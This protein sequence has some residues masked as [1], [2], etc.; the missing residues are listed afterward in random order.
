MTPVTGGTAGM[1]AGGKPWPRMMV[2]AMALDGLGVLAL[3]IPAIWLITSDITANNQGGLAT[4]VGYILLVPAAVFVIAGLLVLT[5]YKWARLVHSALTIIWIA[6]W[7][8]LLSMLR[9]PFLPALSIC[10]AA[11]TVLMWLP[12]SKQF[13]RQS[14]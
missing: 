14:D 10:F 7:I 13:F 9:T 6:V 3:V 4:I 8:D 5:R 1:T 2:I 12:P 11:A